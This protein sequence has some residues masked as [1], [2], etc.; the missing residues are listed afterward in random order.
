MKTIANSILSAI[1][2]YCDKGKRTCL[3][4]RLASFE[5]SYKTFEKMPKSEK[6]VE[7]P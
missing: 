3:F 4:P 7:R 5:P 1:T 6:R 2:K